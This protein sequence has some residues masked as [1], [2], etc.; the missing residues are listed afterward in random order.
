M[1]EEARKAN[2]AEVAE[3][4]RKAALPK[5]Y[6]AKRA[7]AEWEEN[8]EKAKAEA[9]AAGLDYERLKNKKRTA[10][11]A[12]AKEYRKKKK[13]PDQV[14]PTSQYYLFNRTTCSYTSLN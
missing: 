3:E 6:E 4:D 9:K 8:E 10:L 12:D 1:K 5:N 13:N 2:T 7:Q 14:R 11:E